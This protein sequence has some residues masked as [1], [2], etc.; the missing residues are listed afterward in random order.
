MMVVEAKERGQAVGNLTSQA[1]GMK[2]RHF[3]II[4][5]SPSPLA[6]PSLNNKAD[7]DDLPGRHHGKHI[8]N[9]PKAVV[10]SKQV[11]LTQRQVNA[12]V[13]EGVKEQKKKKKK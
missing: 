9:D 4:Q 7:V 2:F 1:F 13:L 3:Q 10:T 6:V 11:K 12:P 8:M 5:Q